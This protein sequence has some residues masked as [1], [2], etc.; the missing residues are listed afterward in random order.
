MRNFP[1]FL[2][3]LHTLWNGQVS[4][5]ATLEKLVKLGNFS[6]NEISFRQP[7]VTEGAFTYYARLVNT[8]SV[9]GR[10]LRIIVWRAQPLLLRC[11]RSRRKGRPMNIGI[12]DS[13][14]WVTG[15]WLG[16]VSRAHVG[17]VYGGFPR[18]GFLPQ[19]CSEGSESALGE[20]DRWQSFS[21]AQ[22]Q[23]RKVKD[24]LEGVAFSEQCCGPSGN[25]KLSN[26]CFLFLTFSSFTNKKANR[27]GD[28][29]E[30]RKK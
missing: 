6:V 14:W 22:S 11:P 2:T 16:Q 18:Q 21:E 10:T 3:T 7:T 15:R 8:H 12:C 27:R 25:V 29:S 19:V 5:V 17:G 1:H 13:G 30:E 28:V 4:K 24:I 23:P 20:G 26:V 9:P